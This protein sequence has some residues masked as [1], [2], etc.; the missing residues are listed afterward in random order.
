L[1]E[2]AWQALLNYVN[3]GGSLLI[4]G[5]IDRDQHWQRI[6]RAE[7]IIPGAYAVPITYHNASLSADDRSPA[8]PLMRAW[9]LSFDLEAQSWLEALRFPEGS[10]THVSHGKGVIFWAAEPVELAQGELASADLYAY[11]ARRSHLEPEFELLE[12]L[13][14]AVMVYPISLE[15]AVLYVIVSDSA[16][17]AM[18]DLRDG[19]TGVRL[20]LKLAAE[21]AAVALIGKKE[22]SVLARYGF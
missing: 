4:T 16:E 1:T 14:P 12:P 19:R 18:V 17:H 2:Q 7:T 10:F 6:D 3:G 13:S 15:D 21:H 22:K 9:S 11:V 8:S 20:A 5:A